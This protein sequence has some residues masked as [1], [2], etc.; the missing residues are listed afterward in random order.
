MGRIVA[1]VTITNALDPS[2]AILC[3]ALVD[4][5]ASG[6]VLP[7]A[8]KERLGRLQTVRV[9]AIG[10]ADQRVVRGE[11]C[12]PVRV[13]IEGFAPVLTEVTFLE[14]ESVDGDAEPL[15]GYIV[16]EQSRAAVD[17]VAHRLVKSRYAD[18]KSLAV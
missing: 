8:W 10:T 7:A 9:E 3:D 16:L 11:V 14:M 4:T 2:N 5:G 1:P 15:I 12:G 13:E 17:L 18:L 6:L